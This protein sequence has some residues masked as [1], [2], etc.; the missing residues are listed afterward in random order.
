[1]IIK[2]DD[3]PNGRMVKKITF[4]IEFEDGTPSKDTISI[5]TSG[6]E[7]VPEKSPEKVPANVPEETSAPVI[8]NEE[9]VQKPIPEEMR[10]AQY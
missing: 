7:K 4:D 3:L 8:H 1:M 5:D 10:D 6:P 9:R 2:I